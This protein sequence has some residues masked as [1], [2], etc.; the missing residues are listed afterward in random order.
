MGRPSPSVLDGSRRGLGLGP[1]EKGNGMRG[2]KAFQLGQGGQN[3]KVTSGLVWPPGTESTQR[4]LR[5]YDEAQRTH[6]L[7]KQGRFE[8]ALSLLPSDS[9]EDGHIKLKIA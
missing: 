1:P 3:Q 7:G 5:K 9:D 4:R 6:A 2:A 8:S